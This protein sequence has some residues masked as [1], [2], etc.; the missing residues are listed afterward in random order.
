VELWGKDEIE[1]DEM[2]EGGER[3]MKRK[4]QTFEWTNEE[5]R[6]RRT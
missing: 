1:E 2:D 3:R 4:Y 5:K 6:R